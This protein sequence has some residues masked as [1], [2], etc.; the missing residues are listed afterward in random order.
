[1]LDK[2]FFEPMICRLL[3]E[4]LSY[5]GDLL[6]LTGVLSVDIWFFF[7]CEWRIDTMHD[8]VKI[9]DQLKRIICYT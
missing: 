6:Y 5:V 8:S 1:M 9:F 2:I 3:K 4:S 7:L